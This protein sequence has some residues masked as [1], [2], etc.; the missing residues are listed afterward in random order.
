MQFAAHITRSH[1]PFQAE[2]LPAATGKIIQGTREGDIG[3]IATGAAQ[4]A[5]E[6]HG[7]KSSPLSRGDQLDILAKSQLGKSYSEINLLE[8]FQL[9]SDP[10]IAPLLAEIDAD[11]AARGRVSAEYRVERANAEK[12]LKDFQKQDLDEFIKAYSKDLAWK[13][14][15]GSDRIFGKIGDREITMRGL[16][17][18]FA[19]NISQTKANTYANLAGWRKAK[20]LDNY[21]GKEPT[22]DFDQMLD[23]WYA[24]LDKHTDTTLIGESEYKGILDVQKW[25]PESEDF[26]SKLTPELQQQLAEWRGRKENIEGVQALLDLR[27]PIGKKADGS[28]EFHSDRALYEEINKILT[29]MVTKRIASQ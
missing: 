7:A 8:R 26:I 22:N 11:L 27:G 23:D 18:D 20:G 5:L 19:E 15:R 4:I 16:L 28:N 13:Q 24:L 3:Q 14:V 12:A 29:N 21:V 1:L 25:V 2:E 9:E 17:D 6:G 10:E